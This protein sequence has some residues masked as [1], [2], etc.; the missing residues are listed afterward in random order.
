METAKA[1]CPASISL[2]FKVHEHENPVKMGS[3]GIG[4]TVDKGVNAEVEISDKTIIKWNGKE[5]LFPTVL[6]VIKKLTNKP[7]AVN[8][9][10]TLPLGS[11]YG[12]SGSSALA[13]GSAINKLLGLRKARKKLIEIAYIAETK[14]KT[15]LGTVTTQAIGGFLIKKTPGLNPKHISLPFTGKKVYAL[16]VSK[17]E[18]PKVLKNGTKIIKIN[19]AVDNLLNKINSIKQMRLDD[20]LDLSRKF[21]F[22]AD[23]ITDKK[24]KITLDDMLKHGHHAT[25]TMLG[26]V[27]ITT[28]KP[29]NNYGFPVS[30]VTITKDSFILL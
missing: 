22:N 21:A 26:N 19:T 2:I 9:I 11:G 29:S 5:I 8:L 13:T 28:E 7:I 12:L 20:F 17:K 6:Y 15:G 24:I 10:S 16:F 1:Y 14:N 27:I 3:T 4:F 23:L 30:S 25:I 18:T